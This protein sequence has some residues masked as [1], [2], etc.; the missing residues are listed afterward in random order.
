[1]PSPAPAGPPFVTEVK[2]EPYVTS[3]RAFGVLDEATAEVLD[4]CLSRLWA[5]GAGMVDL[6]LRGILYAHDSATA[7]LDA[8]ADRAGDEAGD[9]LLTPPLLQSGN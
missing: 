3:V 7:T 1:M 8:W 4:E 2:V 6:D 9:L 5:E